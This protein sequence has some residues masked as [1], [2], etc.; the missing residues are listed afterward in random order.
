MP[1][2]VV[3][4][5]ATAAS[6]EWYSAV[7]RMSASSASRYRASRKSGLN[8]ARTVRHTQSS[9]SLIPAGT[10]SARN[11]RRYAG[12]PPTMACSRAASAGSSATLQKSAAGR[13]PKGRTTSSSCA[14]PRRGAVGASSPPMT[15]IAEPHRSNRIR[16][17]ST[18][19]RSIARWMSEGSSGA[20][21]TK[22]GNSSMTTRNG[23]SLRP[24]PA[25][26]KRYEIASSHVAKEKGTGEPEWSARAALNWAEGLRLRPRR[27]SE[28]EASALLDER[29]QEV[30]LPHA[31]PAADDPE[32]GVRPGRFTKEVSASHSLPRS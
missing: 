10:S 12:V 22:Y 18:W 24:A 2:R 30:R 11:W 23:L 9:K 26:S 29:P 14:R 20:T 4:P 1:P 6:T 16:L 3:L 8:G 25:R 31:S 32:H 5:C 28:V 7:S 21:F 15:D 17:S 13:Y 27:G 19:K